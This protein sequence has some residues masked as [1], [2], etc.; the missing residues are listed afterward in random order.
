MADNSVVQFPSGQPLANT[1][2]KLAQNRTV[3]GIARSLAGRKH[4]YISANQ[5]EPLSI[6]LSEL[7]GTADPT[8]L[9]LTTLARSGILTPAS[10]ARL[11]IRHASEV[12]GER[13]GARDSLGVAG[14]YGLSVAGDPFGK[15][16]LRLES[17]NAWLVLAP[18]SSLGLLAEV[19]PREGMHLCTLIACDATRRTTIRLLMPAEWRRRLTTLAQGTNRCGCHHVLLL[20][21]I[22][23][24]E[25]ER[26]AAVS[27]IE[28]ALRRAGHMCLL[29]SSLAKRLATNS[30]D[31]SQA[32]SH[33]VLAMVEL[34]FPG[35]V[36]VSAPAGSAAQ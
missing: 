12:S 17:R 25:P 32:S 27:R 22:A 29:S 16:A 34:A 5:E 21:G 36:D 30:L 19:C 31:A 23:S 9:Q 2:A 4:S 20:G 6:R 3:A 28:Q 8:I 14:R 35:L 11:A 33:E 10:A 7:A 13:L 26:S 15:F 1:F 24:T 18:V